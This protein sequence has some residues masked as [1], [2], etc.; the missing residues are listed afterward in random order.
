MAVLFNVQIEEKPIE[1]IVKVEAYK[2]INTEI[3]EEVSYDI[4]D[5]YDF[6]Q[7]LVDLNSL[8]D[9]DRLYSCGL[10]SRNMILQEVKRYRF[11][12]EF[13]LLVNALKH[14]HRT[15]KDL[16]A[17]HIDN[18]CRSSKTMVCYLSGE[19]E[20][21]LNK[22][23]IKDIAFVYITIIEQVKL[24]AEMAFNNRRMRKLIKDFNEVHSM[25]YTIQR[26][27]SGFTVKDRFANNVTQFS[28]FELLRLLAHVI[29]IDY[30]EHNY[31]YVSEDEYELFKDLADIDGF[32][33]MYI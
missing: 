25:Y 27:G 32:H 14:N 33:H 12:N 17:K 11:E 24:N 5:Y 29:V 8:I 28:K 18:S 2:I 4:Y 31:R 26:R 20:R 19:D 22:I 13:K 30:Y 16:Y 9:D 10:F 6:Y 15:V 3:I 1:H 21:N 7:A 23:T